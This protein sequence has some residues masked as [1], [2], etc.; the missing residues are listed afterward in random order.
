M[1]ENTA[2]VRRFLEEQAKIV[3]GGGC[4][5]FTLDP[6]KRASPEFV[7]HFYAKTGIR[8]RINGQTVTLGVEDTE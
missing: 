8:C 3:E 2:A 6:K 5:K 7:R 4:H 1:K